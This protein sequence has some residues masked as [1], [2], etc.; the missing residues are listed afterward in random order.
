MEDLTSNYVENFL[1]N[2]MFGLN[3]HPW[4]LS[5]NKKQLQNL[6]ALSLYLSVSLS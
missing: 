2:I 3:R 6:I 1:N 4:L 5:R